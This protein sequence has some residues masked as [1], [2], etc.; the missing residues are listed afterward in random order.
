M[1]P[2][3]KAA[4]AAIALIAAVTALGAWD[5]TRQ[6]TEAGGV[7]LRPFLGPWECYDAASLRPAKPGN[8]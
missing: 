1:T 6:C 3:Q 5:S 4:V 7:R 2:L 8:N